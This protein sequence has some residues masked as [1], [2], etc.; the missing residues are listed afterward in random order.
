MARF[1][2]SGDLILFGAWESHPPQRVIAFEDQVASHGGLGGEQSYP[3]IMCADHQQLDPSQLTNACDLY[4]FFSQT[5]HA[6]NDEVREGIGAPPT[7]QSAPRFRD[8]RDQGVD[9]FQSWSEISIGMNHWIW[10]LCGASVSY[11]D[12]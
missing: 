1:P 11:R 6:P 4:T 9:L 3:F 5:Y 12:G 2:H 7:G 10:V 8:K